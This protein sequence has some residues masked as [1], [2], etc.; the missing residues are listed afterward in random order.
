VRFNDLINVRSGDMP[1]P[2]SVGIDHNVRAMLTL[3]ETTRLIGAY[4]ALH[5]ELG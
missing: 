3:V 5:P 2:D 4:T 1:I